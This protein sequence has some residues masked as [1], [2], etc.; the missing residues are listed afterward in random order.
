MDDGF[1]GR[2]ALAEE[3]AEHFEAARAE[4]RSI[5]FEVIAATALKD[6]W[7]HDPHLPNP[8]SPPPPFKPDYIALL[9]LR[10]DPN[11][12]VEVNHACY[13]LDAATTPDERRDKALAILEDKVNRG[14][15]FGEQNLA[16]HPPYKHRF[17]DIWK[18]STRTLDSGSLEDFKFRSPNEI[19]ILLHHEGIAVDVLD[20]RLLGF[21]THGAD[22]KIRQPNDTFYNA[23]P[24]PT[25]E[26]PA[27]LRTKASLIRVENYAT[28]VDTTTPTTPLVYAMDINFQIKAGNERVTMVVDP[29]TG[30][31]TGNEP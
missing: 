7:G 15:T 12:S 25:D 13:R 14:V 3:L 9:Y 26:L 18:D 17:A 10:L 2:T 24:V 20:K 21:K 22:N 29:D 8:H 31:G 19:F 11:W 16:A 30:N 23:R 5:A 28:D 1:A 6:Y 4:V 27:G